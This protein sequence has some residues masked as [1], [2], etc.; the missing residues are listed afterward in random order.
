MPAALKSRFFEYLQA[1]NQPQL[2][3]WQAWVFLPGMAFRSSRQWWG[4][5][6]PRPAPHEGI[7]LCCFGDR[8]GRLNWVEPPLKIPATFAGTIV[9]ISGDFLGQSLFLS[10]EI[11]ADN[12][13][14][15]FTIYGH[16][17]P[18]PGLA[19]GQ[20]VTEGEII[21]ELALPATKRNIPPHL[22]LSFAWVH[23]PLSLSQL[24]WAT[25]GADPE[26]TLLD[27]L[28]IL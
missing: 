23:V 2:A 14:Q 21:A 12:G 8:G 24:D 26:I 22:H 19:L 25:L 17:R 27:P 16:T 7:D 11:Y 6:K 1:N 13:E 15:L 10:H 20:P 18:R 9:K 3:D 28:V 5:E 4:G